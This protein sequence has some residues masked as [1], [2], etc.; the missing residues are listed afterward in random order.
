MPRARTGRASLE[1]RRM[2]FR[3]QWIRTMRF[4]TQAGAEA[5]RPHGLG[6]DA[7]HVYLKWGDA[8]GFRTEV[9]DESPGEAVAS[10]A[11]TVSFTGDSRIWVAAHRN[12]RASLGAQITLRFW[13]QA[14]H[15]PLHR[16]SS[17]GGR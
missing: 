16:C 1:F 14:P 7:A 4:S 12:G 10:R 8:R 13:K 6:T 17:P 15:F 3:A 9:I 5:R 2:R 11:Q